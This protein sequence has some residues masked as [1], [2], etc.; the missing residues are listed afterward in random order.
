MNDFTPIEGFDRD[1]GNQGKNLSKHGVS[2]LECEEVFFNLPLL[3]GYD[4]RHSGLEDRYYAYGRT[5]RGR[6]LFLVF[7]TRLGKIRVISARE[8]TKPERGRYPS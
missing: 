2:D 4:E 1:E 8:M 6:P 5:A 3:V 7:T